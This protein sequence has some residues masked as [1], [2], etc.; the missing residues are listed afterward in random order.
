M[1]CPAKSVDAL[2]SPVQPALI[3]IIV[4]PALRVV[5]QQPTNCGGEMR[6]C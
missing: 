5:A 2:Q 6:Y 1:L 3:L 4:L